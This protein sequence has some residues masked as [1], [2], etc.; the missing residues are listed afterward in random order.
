MSCLYLCYQ[1]LME[2]LTQTQV[3]S[4]LEGLARAGYAMHLLTFEPRPPSAAAAQ[5]WRER[6]AARNITWHWRHYHKRPTVP[7]TAWDV[8]QGVA[9]ALPL[10]W[11]HGVQLVHARAHVPGLMALALKKLTGARFL[12]DVR[13]LL[14]EE[15]VDAGNWPAGGLLFRLTKRVERTLVRGADGVVLLTERARELFRAWYPRELAGKPTE[16]IPCCV[17]LRAVPD[18]ATLDGRANGNNQTL[19]YAGKL[20][21]WYPTREM[22]EFFAVA[23]Q[24]MPG[25]HWKV[26]TQSDPAPLRRLLAERGLVAEVSVGLV[27]PDELPAA[28]AGAQAGLCLYRRDLS[29]AACSPTKVPEYLA[30]GLPV[31]ANAGTGDVDALLGSGAEPVG[32]LLRELSPAAYREAVPQLQRLLREPDIRR[33]C[34]R[35]AEE[36]F[37]LERVGWARYRA[38]YR[39]LL[40]A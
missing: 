7:A 20:G 32:V 27:L 12:F 25:L 31:V 29:R 10:V 33:R 34:R 5:A 36:Q 19:V 4:Y 14:A 28:L 26:C 3:V 21:G 8:C 30:L 38:I 16:V 40:G 2:P 9:A 24:Q 18:P 22:V 23:R 39:S 6:L 1:S 13:G 11:R 17:D 15:Y 35:V 37:D